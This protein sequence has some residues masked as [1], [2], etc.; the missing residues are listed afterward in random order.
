MLFYILFSV[1]LCL[2]NTVKHVATAS[3]HAYYFET[4]KLNG[5]HAHITTC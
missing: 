2:N 5:T 3:Y 4:Q 1:T